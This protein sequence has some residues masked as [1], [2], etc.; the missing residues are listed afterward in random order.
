M[1]YTPDELRSICIKKT[2]FDGYC[3][4]QV[5]NLLALVNEDYTKLMRENQELT[6]QLTVLNESVKHYKL[7]EE[8]LQHSIIVTQHASEQVKANACE[9]ARIIMDEAEG[10]AQR[11][12]TEANRE[13]T[14]AKSKIEELK[15][16][17]FTF[18]AKSEALIQGQLEVLKQ[19]N[20]E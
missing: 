3:K 1:N 20:I 7:L 4:R 5:D 11:L 18:K 12:I 2:I 10:N 13:V 9:K 16:E 14:R 8:S 15:A 6:N 17:M 19:M